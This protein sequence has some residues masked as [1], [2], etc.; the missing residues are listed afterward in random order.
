VSGRFSS[1]RIAIILVGTNDAAGATAGAPA[2]GV[3]PS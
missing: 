3:P 2:A 1:G